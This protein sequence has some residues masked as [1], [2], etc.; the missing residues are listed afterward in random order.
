MLDSSFS[1][2]L[3]L[4]AASIFGIT[5]HI[6]RI[7]LND[8]NPIL[9]SFL[10]VF[11]TAICFWAVAPIALEPEWL[12]TR[13]ALYF[14]AIGVLAPALGQAFQIASVPKVGPSLTASIGAF[15][16]TFAVVT[17]IFILSEAPSNSDYF[18]IF[19]MTAALF[20]AGWNPKTQP[21]YFSLWMLLLPLSAA[22]LVVTALTER[23]GAHARWG[24]RRDA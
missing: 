16:P 8:T 14:L 19:L 15:T 12:V 21:R 23:F 9:G 1:V 5:F 13:E 10:T 24:Y 4:G 11:A 17:A 3:A 20:I 18:G 22:V 6:Q 7:A 2:F